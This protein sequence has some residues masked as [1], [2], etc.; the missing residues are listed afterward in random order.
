M[1]DSSQHI[2]T[3]YR[4]CAHS[5]QYPESEWLTDQY[6]ESL[7]SLLKVLDADKEIE[8]IKQFFRNS[9]DPIEEL[10]I[11]HTRLFIN[12]FPH[13]VAPPYGSVYLDKSLQGKHAEKTMEFYAKHGFHLKDNADLPD[14]LIHELEFLSLLADSDNQ[15]AEAEFLHTLFRPWFNKFS[16]RVQLESNS[17]FYLV[18][19][20]F[21]DYLTK[22]DNEHGI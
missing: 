20:Q 11:E 2:A 19:V 10:Q 9:P 5:M 22:E 1:H 14:H 4:F 3:L 6:L 8:S 12:G 17:Q 7:F 18:I 13:V 21:I 16:S 15:E